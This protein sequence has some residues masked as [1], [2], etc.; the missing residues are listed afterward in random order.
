M[1]P[2]RKPGNTLRKTDRR[3]PSP[4]YRRLCDGGK[5]RRAPRV[6]AL[7]R[8][9]PNGFRFNGIFARPYGRQSTLGGKVFHD[10]DI[11]SWRTFGRALIIET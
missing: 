4:V 9:R 5:Q 2:M 7:I 1:T 11:M 8:Q 3:W 6:V 10:K